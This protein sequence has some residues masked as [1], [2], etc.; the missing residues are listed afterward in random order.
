[1]KKLWLTLMAIALA[2]PAVSM[3]QESGVQ[4]A[5]APPGPDKHG[6]VMYMTQGGPGMHMGMGMG[7]H[8]KW[9]KNADL[10]QQIGVSD[11]QVQQ[12][13]K[14]FQDNRMKLIDLHAALEK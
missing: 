2:V 3:A 1:M 5:P 10:V 4:T 6:N 7:M 8:G 13:E 11:A 14:I 12:M 9:W